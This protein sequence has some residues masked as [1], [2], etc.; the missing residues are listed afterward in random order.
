MGGFKVGKVPKPRLP[1]DAVEGF[2]AK[3]DEVAK[4]TD[5]APL[6]PRAMSAR[7]WEGM[8]PDAATSR[9]VN[10]RLNAYEHEV[11]KWL[12]ERDD[13]SLQYTLK[14]LLK[15]AMQAEIASVK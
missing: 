1:P 4:P 7:P 9:G 15:Q 14:R 13:R 5:R 3:A 10:L 2:A 11:L 8:D 6:P 12:A